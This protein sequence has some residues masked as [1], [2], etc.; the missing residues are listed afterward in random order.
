MTP[1]YDDIPAWPPQRWTPPLSPDFPSAFDGYREL[2]RL[3]WRAAFGYVL[4]DWQE[5]TIRHAL[6]I[7][8][9]GHPRAGQLR[10]RQVVISLGRQN[11]KTEIAAAIG[12]WALLM[13]AIPSVVGIA[14]NADQ[15]RLVYSR[16]M[17]AIRGTPQLKARFKA[18]TETR[19]IQT[20]SGGAYEIK[21]A[22]SAALQGIP[23]DVGLVDELHLLVRAL[24]FDLVNGLGGRANCLVVGITTAGDSTES[25]L[26]LFLYDQGDEAIAKGGEARFGFY[27]WE[28]LAA[29]MPEQTPDE[30]ELRR[31][32]CRANP[33]L[34]SGRGGVER[35]D[36]VVEEVRGMPAQDAIRYRLNRFTESDS[37]FMTV[38]GWRLLRTE[39]PFPD[40]RPV[41]TIDRTPDW[42]YASIGAFAI[43]PADGKTYADLVASYVSP[44]LAQLAD[45]CVE[46]HRRHHAVTFGMDG[47]VLKDLGRELERRGLPVTITTYGDM[48]NGSALFY[49]KVQRGTIKHPG[50]ELLDRQIPVTGRK[51][52]NDGFKI[53][54]VDSSGEIDGVL[55]HVIGV[56]LAEVTTPSTLQ[57]F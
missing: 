15:A 34:A 57:I 49:A 1:H 36:N 33:S 10:F 25:E 51:N 9:P 50:H 28:A 8:P 32:L 43:D 29:A 22:K 24:W 41:F 40:V 46:L 27:V 44:T 23:V 45:V 14:S 4:E 55:N 6:E 26:L 52:V 7:Y 47:Y 19:G 48:L 17:Q 35:L 3:I 18:L 12:L 31:E 38:H 30:L 16:T 2:F 56:Q 37:A 21:A 39:D 5:Q 13:K 42:G 53:S 54:R 20:Y 11:G